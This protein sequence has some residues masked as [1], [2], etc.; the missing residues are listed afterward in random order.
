MVF[1]AILGI[2]D[3]VAG[4]L[5]MFSNN[6]AGVSL[7][8]LM[9]IIILIKALYSLGTA[10]AAGFYFDLL[11]ILDL[12]AAVFLLLAFYGIFFH[13]FIYIG[14]MMVVKGFYSIIM[15]LLEQ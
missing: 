6:F 15:M 4:V 12:I 11:G 2:I 14:I 13:F 1:L 10:F 7:I 9:G 8:L 5:L 3:L